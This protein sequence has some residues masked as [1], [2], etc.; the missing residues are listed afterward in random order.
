[1]RKYGGVFIADEVQ[2][3][4]G[5]TGAKW[6]GIEHYGVEPDM[7]TMAKGI[8]NGYPLSAVVATTALAAT[9]AKKGTI[10]TFGGNP[11][12]CSASL[13]VL[14]EIES[15]DLLAN[16][17]VRGRELRAGLEHVQRQFPRVI[18]DVRGMGLMQAMELVVDETAG[19]RTPNPQAVLRLFEET[20]L[21]K[22]LIGRGGLRANIL[23]IAPPLNVTAAEVTEAVSILEQSFAAICAA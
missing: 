1:V 20:K 23:R 11:V 6:W 10:A 17:E 4:F 7:M 19:D 2:T 13:A 22:L 21:R 9:V 18:G 3:G 15:A 14:E 12:S 8:A 5:R 16:A